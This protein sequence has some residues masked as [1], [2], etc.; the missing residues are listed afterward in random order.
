MKFEPSDYGARHQLVKLE[1]EHGKESTVWDILD[2]CL[3]LIGIHPTVSLRTSG[4]EPDKCLIALEFLPQYEAFRMQF[5]VSDYWN[6]DDPLY[7]LPFPPPRAG[8]IEAALT[9]YLAIPFGLG[10]K[11]LE[12][13]SDRSSKNNIKQFFELL[14]PYVERAVVESAREFSS[15]IPSSKEEPED[16][17]SKLTNVIMFVGLV[18]LR[19]FGRQRGWIAAQF[20]VSSKAM[21]CAL[22]DYDENKIQANVINSLLVLNE[23]VIFAPE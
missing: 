18:A 12:E 19:E 23:E 17:A 10:M 9:T 1:L 11:V 14:Q 2:E 13:L 16:L 3:E 21:N 6:P 7:D 20:G 8:N 5:P 22:G 4:L 15:L